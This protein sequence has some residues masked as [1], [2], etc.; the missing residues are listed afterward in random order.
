MPVGL[1]NI[2]AHVNK[3]L[4]TCQSILRKLKFL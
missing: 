1:N 3:V 2:H 4:R